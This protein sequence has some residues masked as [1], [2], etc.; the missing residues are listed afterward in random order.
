MRMSGE[1]DRRLL[2][3]LSSVRLEAVYMAHVTGGGL[4]CPVCGWV[5]TRRQP[6]CRSFAVAHALR[7]GRPVPDWRGDEPPAPARVEVEDQMELFAVGEPG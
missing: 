1:L 3:E 2:G 5:P 7:W 4:V 6:H